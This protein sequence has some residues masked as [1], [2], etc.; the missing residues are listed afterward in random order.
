MWTLPL[1]DER[2][3][4]PGVLPAQH[5]LDVDAEHPVAAGRR[6]PLECVLRALVPHLQVERAA[7]LQLQRQAVHGRL[8]EEGGKM[9]H[10]LVAQLV[11]EPRTG[12]GFM[13]R[14]KQM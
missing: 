5:R 1:D 13:C 6:Q 3:P 4:E 8:A 12:N 14:M 10:A 11:A 9:E 2:H 7:R